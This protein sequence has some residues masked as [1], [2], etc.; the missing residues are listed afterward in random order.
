MNQVVHQLL[1]PSLR[2]GAAW[3]PCRMAEAS[4]GDRGS[5]PPEQCWPAQFL[6]DRG[7]SSCV[8]FSILPSSL[9]YTCAN[10]SSYG[11]GAGG[12]RSRPVVAI[13]SWQ[14]IFIVAVVTPPGSNVVPV[15]Y[16]SLMVPLNSAQCT[17]TSGRFV[18]DWMDIAAAS[19]YGSKMCT[20]RC[21]VVF[22]YQAGHRSM[23]GTPAASRVSR[24]WMFVG[25]SYVRDRNSMLWRVVYDY[26]SVHLFTN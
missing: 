17:E 18:V 26:K 8:W 9:R 12:H 1:C 4:R 15:V 7:C 22:F 14:V 10:H 13:P 25:V 21:T 19:V 5:S 20:L 24:Q 6:L 16:A 3:L 11:G 2:T 23:Y